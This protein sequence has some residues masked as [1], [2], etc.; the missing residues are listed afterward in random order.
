MDESIIYTYLGYQAGLLQIFPLLTPSLS[1]AVSLLTTRGRPS[2]PLDS[3]LNSALS[4]V[5]NFPSTNSW[6]GRI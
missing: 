1:T 6:N 5:D 4:L 3:L 2:P